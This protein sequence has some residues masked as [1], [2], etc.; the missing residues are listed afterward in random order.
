VY[1]RIR[2]SYGNPTIDGELHPPA[3]LSRAWAL[4]E[5]FLSPRVLFFG[6]R[7]MFYEC[8]TASLCECSTDQ[9]LDGGDNRRAD[10]RKVM[11]SL[12]RDM[13]SLITFWHRLVNSYSSM[14][15]TFTEDVLP[16]ISGL[17]HR[18]Q[19]L[20]GSQ[21]YA[22]IWSHSILQDLTW[23]SSGS[24]LPRP[25]KYQAPTWSWASTGCPSRYDIHTGDTILPND[26][27][28]RVQDISCTLK[29]SDPC[30]EV[31]AGHIVIRGLVFSAELDYRLDDSSSPRNPYQGLLVRKDYLSTD[32]TVLRFVPDHEFMR[33]GPQSLPTG[34]GIF[35]F[36]L[37]V[38]RFETQRPTAVSN[39]L[40]ALILRDSPAAENC[41]ERIGFTA[42]IIRD[43]FII[44]K[45]EMRTVRII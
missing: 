30:G 28:P 6:P 32:G 13:E 7:E 22:G 11:L 1:V 36:L 25:E 37:D 29:S 24:W 16:A 12:G 33:D 40:L 3:L 45:A 26:L 17:A 41:F 43:N 44:E 10:F 4:Q 18:L 9:A 31:V 39:I 2:G 38:K 19:G 21:Y 20:T 34:T 35:C 8:N 5:R 27:L 42:Q 14:N 15:L 23:M